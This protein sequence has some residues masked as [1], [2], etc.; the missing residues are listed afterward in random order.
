MRTYS[1]TELFRLTRAELLALHAE[2][3]KALASLP[4][5]DASRPVLLSTLR[6]IRRVLATPHPTP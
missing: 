3:T 2:T 6:A 4:A 5:N 1:L